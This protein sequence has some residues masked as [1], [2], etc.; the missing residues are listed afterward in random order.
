MDAGETITMST[1]GCQCFDQNLLADFF[2]IQSNILF[3]YN[4]IGKVE[5]NSER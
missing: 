5:L 1:T 4:I 3:I 2:K